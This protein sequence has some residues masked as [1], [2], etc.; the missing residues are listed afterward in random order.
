MVEILPSL[1]K[2]V[3]LDDI[4]QILEEDNY[5]LSYEIKPEGDRLEEQNMDDN[6][7]TLY[8]WNEK[9][10]IKTGIIDFISK[11]KDE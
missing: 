4:F 5:C 9:F 1:D 2:Y 8:G 6:I 7:S 3:Y 11:V 10:N